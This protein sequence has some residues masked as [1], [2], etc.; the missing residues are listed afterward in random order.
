[1]PY[2]PPILPTTLILIAGFGSL[3]LLM[4]ILFAKR[5]ITRFKFRSRRA[6]HNTV[7]HNAPKRLQL[8][9][10]H[11]LQRTQQI[12]GFPRLLSDDDYRLQYL[13]NTDSERCTYVYRMKAVDA[14]VHF[15]E[16]VKKVDTRLARSTGVSVR[17]HI[18]QLKVSPLTPL[19]GAS[20]ALCRAYI[21]AYEHARFGCKPFGEA[22][23]NN[24]MA[25]LHEL[26]SCLRHKS[27][28]KRKASQSA[29]SSQGG[30]RSSIGSQYSQVSGAAANVDTPSSGSRTLPSGASL[31]HKSAVQGSRSVSTADETTRL[32][33]GSSS[34]SQSQ[35]I[36]DGSTERIHLIR[37]P[38]RLHYHHRKDSS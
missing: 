27:H 9:I 24:Y 25:L 20:D 2:L 17:D 16:Q 31:Y 37:N 30:A 11:L 7:G 3:F 14:F 34:Q 19:K 38:D 32:T 26:I 15:E 21:D 1:M 13:A 22:E 18:K 4:V 10:E 28:K 5:Q 23:Y 12:K 8:E 6:P 35:T 36:Y 33:D 29:L